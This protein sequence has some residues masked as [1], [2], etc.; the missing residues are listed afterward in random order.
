MPLSSRPKKPIIMTEFSTSVLK[1]IKKIPK[2]KVASYGQ[3]AALAGKPHGARGVG[4]LLN[5][6]A[7]SHNLPWH[8]VISS[9]GRISFPRDSREFTFQR[10]LLLKE[11]VKVSDTGAVPLKTYWKK[12]HQVSAVIPK[13][14]KSLRSSDKSSGLED[15]FHNFG[16]QEF[17]RVTNRLY[18]LDQRLS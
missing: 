17:M 11:G 5:S 6:C 10:T 9:Q 2:G 7:D 18:T 13:N 8:R 1:W 4:W 16:G 3:I 14:L 15:R 12:Q